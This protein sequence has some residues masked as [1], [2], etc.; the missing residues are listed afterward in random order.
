MIIMIMIIMMKAMLVPGCT[1]T[2][3]EAVSLREALY[4]DETALSVGCLK[5]VWMLLVYVDCT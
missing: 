5:G 3:G 1:A 4:G 2:S